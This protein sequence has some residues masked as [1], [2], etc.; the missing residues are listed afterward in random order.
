[1]LT[2]IFVSVV[3]CAFAI[4]RGARAADI[5]QAGTFRCDFTTS[6]GRAL[7]QDGTTETSGSSSMQDLVFA[8][9]DRQKRR[10]VFVGNAGSSPVMVLDGLE[11]VSFIEI[12]DAGNVI[13]TSIFKGP[14][15]LDFKTGTVYYAAVMSRHLGMG[16]AKTAM[17]SQ[18]YGYCRGQ[19]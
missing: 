13:L 12:T 17:V 10:A 5:N 6:A 7:N 3:L 4:P 16:L 14:G 2:R 1:M 9:V 18:F 19:L 8:Q 11:T 15:L